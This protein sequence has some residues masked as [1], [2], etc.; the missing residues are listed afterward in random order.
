MPDMKQSYEE[1]YIINIYNECQTYRDGV[2]II[3]IQLLPNTFSEV[4]DG[5]QGYHF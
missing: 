2:I 4:I 3:G 5:N 1:L